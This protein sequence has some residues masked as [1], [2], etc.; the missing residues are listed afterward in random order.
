MSTISRTARQVCACDKKAGL[1]FTQ[2]FRES[3]PESFT[4]LLVT[5]IVS[6]V[7]FLKEVIAFSRSQNDKTFL[8]LITCSRHYDIPAKTRSRMTAA[9]TFSRQNDAGSRA[10]YLG[11][12]QT[13]T[14]TSFTRDLS[15]FSLC[16]HGTL[17]G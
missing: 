10:H 1:P 14:D 16:S 15:I 17:N 13:A 5:R 7:M 11:C 9:I 2:R 6:R 12:I 4:V 3:S 8:A